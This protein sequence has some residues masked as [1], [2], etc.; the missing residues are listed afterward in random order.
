MLFTI[1]ETMLGH[2]VIK[3][4]IMI[5]RAFVPGKLIDGL[6]VMADQEAELISH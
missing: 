4:V 3:C 6:T 2:T 5:P 1:R